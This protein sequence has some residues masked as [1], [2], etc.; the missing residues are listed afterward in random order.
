M[1]LCIERFYCFGNFGLK[2]AGFAF[3]PMHRIFRLRFYKIVVLCGQILMSKREYGNG[4]VFVSWKQPRI[5]VFTVIA[6]ICSPPL[7][8][9]KKN[10]IGSL[11]ESRS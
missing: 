1:E 6:Y 8:I 4:S 3:Q 2:Y 9:S 5:I 7:K 11:F 10:K